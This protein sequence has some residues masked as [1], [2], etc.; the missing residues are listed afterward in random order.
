MLSW[1]C[2]KHT[3]MFYFLELPS[4]LNAHFSFF[5]NGILFL[6]HGFNKFTHNRVDSRGWG[7]WRIFLP[8]PACVSFLQVPF[9]ADSGYCIYHWTH[10]SIFASPWLSMYI[11]RVDTKMPIGH[12]CDK[13]IVDLVEGWSIKEPPFFSTREVTQVVVSAF[14]SFLQGCWFSWEGFCLGL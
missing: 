4:S 7:V 9:S 12:Q 1:F 5:K 8:L 2:M 14:G 3:F 13:G 11:L 6:F 10:P